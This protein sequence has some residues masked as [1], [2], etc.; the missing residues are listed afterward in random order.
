VS[1][2]RLK[3]NTRS[4]LSKPAGSFGSFSRRTQILK[5]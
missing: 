1:Q 2:Q 3:Y 5:M 4:S